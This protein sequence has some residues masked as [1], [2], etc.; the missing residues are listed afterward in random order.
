M[1]GIM[2]SIKRLAK[3]C[4]DHQK[5]TRNTSP[6]IISDENTGE[7]AVFRP[8]AMMLVPMI[9]AKN[10][11]ILMNPQGFSI[12]KGIE[13]GDCEVMAI[14]RMLIGELFTGNCKSCSEISRLIYLAI[15]EISQDLI[16]G[17]V[18]KN[19]IAAMTLIKYGA[20]ISHLSV[21][22]G[23]M[24]KDGRTNM[25][26]FFDIAYKAIRSRLESS[27]PED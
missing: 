16:L 24:H 4:E 6:L 15:E 13:V 1:R 27:E 20:S 9:F 21:P 2:N 11:A 8:D 10:G 18:L 25:N 14:V 19:M 7:S 12:K 26:D 17:E 22:G 3:W 5:D 23:P